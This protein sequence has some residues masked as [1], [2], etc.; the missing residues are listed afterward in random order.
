M[1]NKENGMRELTKTTGFDVIGD[2]HGYAG[3]L[4][5]LLEQM[6]YKKT[7]HGYSHPS[8]TAIFVGDFID[9]GPEQLAVIETV[10]DMIENG[11]ALS[12]MGNHELNAIGWFC[13][14]N[15]GNYLRPHSEKNHH[16]HSEFLRQIGENTATHN[17]WVQWFLSLP[18]WFDLPE[19]QVTHACWHP[20]KMKEL[21]PFLSS[22]ITL[23]QQELPVFFTHKHPAFSAIET[24]MKG[25]ET[26]LP[27]GSFFVDNNGLRRTKTRV[28]WWSSGERYCDRDIIP[29]DVIKNLTNEPLTEELSQLM[30]V[31]KPT[32]I[33]H[34]W[35][36]GIPFIEH[37]HI[38]CLDYSV[39]KSGK[40]VAYRHDAG[41]NLNNNKFV[42]IENKQH[43]K[44]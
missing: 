42:W 6:G 41:E 17:E 8:R 23:K 11:N 4:F 30:H 36:T 20:E 40:L 10:R 15:H 19:L 24:I 25:I 33:G 2:I 43:K 21:L 18:V 38:A 26:S 37:K 1:S 28:K 29:S 35:L 14:D 5:A 9:R 13:K 34:Y 16:Q 3:A 27:Q 31:R 32:F 39:A 22:E 7:I 44:D 12:V